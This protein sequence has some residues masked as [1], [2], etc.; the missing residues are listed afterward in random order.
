MKES[1]IM[2]FSAFQMTYSRCWCCQYMP[3]HACSQKTHLLSFFLPLLLILLLNIF[4][5]LYVR[6]AA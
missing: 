6:D 3:R 2:T 1:N 4:V 5:M